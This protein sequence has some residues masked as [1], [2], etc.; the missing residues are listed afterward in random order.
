M[1]KAE[2]KEVLLKS[3]RVFGPELQIHRTIK[4]CAEVINNL[5][6]YID[7]PTSGNSVA[8]KIGELELYCFQMRQI[9]N[10]KL[11]DSFK[12]KK[13]KRLNEWMKII[14]HKNKVKNN[15]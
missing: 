1:N 14:E 7:D 3:L 5:M 6:A 10:T 9:V 15:E 4:V 12:G 11:V 2:R 13:I 8:E